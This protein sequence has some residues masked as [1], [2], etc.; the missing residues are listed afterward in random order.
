MKAF[1]IFCGFFLLYCTTSVSQND[2]NFDSTIYIAAY[3]HILNDSI[4][5]NKNIAVCDSIIDLDRFFFSDYLEN[6]PIEREILKQYRANKKFIWFDT[7]YSQCIDSLFC[8][9]NKLSKNVLFFSNIEDNML[10]VELI[11]QIWQKNKFSY[12]EMSLFNTGYM[13]LFL[14]TDCGSIKAAFRSECIYN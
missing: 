1:N 9:L 4:N 8:K 13:Y 11:P 6:F 12:K 2:C 10:I 5:K 14:F 7:Y 3:N